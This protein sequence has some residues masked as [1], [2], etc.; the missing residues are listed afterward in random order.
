MTIIAPSILKK[1]NIPFNKITQEANEFMI[2][3]PYAYH[4]GYNLGFNIAESTN[5]ALPRWVEY[6]KRST[7]VSF[8]RQKL[9]NYFV[10]FYFSV[11]VTR[12]PLEYE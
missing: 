7:M 1:N 11:F 4:A 3:F 5:F 12:T 10:N 2:T 6:G 9:K 8:N